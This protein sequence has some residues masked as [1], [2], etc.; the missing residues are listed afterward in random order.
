LLIDWAELRNADHR[1]E[2][3]DGATLVVDRPII[4]ELII[5]F[6]RLE[7]ELP[8][9]ER[10]EARCRLLL[11]AQLEAVKPGDPLM[12]QFWQF[13]RMQHQLVLDPDQ[14]LAL[15]GPLLGGAWHNEAV[16]AV[17]TELDRDKTVRSLARTARDGLRTVADPGSRFVGVSDLFRPPRLLL[18]GA[19]LAA[20]L[21]LVVGVGL[22]H[23]IRSIRTMLLTAAVDLPGLLPRDYRLEETTKPGSEAADPGDMPWT[24]LSFGKDTPSNWVTMRRANTI[25]FCNTEEAG[26]LD[27]FGLTSSPADTIVLDHVRVKYYGSMDGVFKFKPSIPSESRVLLDAKCKRTRTTISAENFQFGNWLRKIDGNSLYLRSD[28][29]DLEIQ[30]YATGNGYFRVRARGQT[31][32]LFNNEDEPCSRP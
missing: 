17:K 10:L 23:E 32:T 18:A 2:S 30:L 3:G 14:A 31:C 6:R 11:L 19:T 29:M 24:S 28:K 4:H 22:V 27:A 5:E 21:L 1:A 20:V 26:N 25:W 16:D 15:L 8:E 12:H 7:A 9:A 13:K